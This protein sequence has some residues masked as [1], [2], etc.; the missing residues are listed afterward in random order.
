MSEYSNEII[1]AN[2]KLINSMKKD[3]PEKF[4]KLLNEKFVNEITIINKYLLIAI[5]VAMQFNH[6]HY[7]NE[8]ISIDN[9]DIKHQ[10]I[11]CFT[12]FANTAFI[13][14]I[15]YKRNTLI[16][17]NTF[18]DI[19][20]LI[21][22]INNGSKHILNEVDIIHHL[23]CHLTDYQEYDKIKQI[24]DDIKNDT[25]ITNE[26]LDKYCNFI[27]YRTVSYICGTKV[28]GKL[29]DYCFKLCEDLTLIESYKIDNGIQIPNKFSC[30]TRLINKAKE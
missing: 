30:F 19:N 18:V 15:K 21:H 11:R 5:E 28:S 8:F 27:I 13:E 7:F 4:I 9:D 3:T 12:I 20:I 2:I 1:L 25:R 29:A 22:K 23:L 26:L 24:L 6:L 16:S 14:K 10:I 17:W